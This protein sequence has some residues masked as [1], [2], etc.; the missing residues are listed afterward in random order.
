MALL[1]LLSRQEPR[2]LRR[3]RHG[4]RPTIPD[5]AASASAMLRDWGAE[6]K[7]HHVLKGYNYPHGGHPGRRPAREAAPPRGVDR[8]PPPAAARYYDQAFA[9]SGVATPPAVA[10][11]AA[12]SIT[13]TPSARPERARWQQE[14]TAQGRPDRHPLPDPGP[15]AAGL[16]GR[17][18]TSAG[19][20]P[21]SEK[22]ADEV[23]SL[24]MYPELTGVQ[25]DEVVAAVLETAKPVGSKPLNF[26]RPMLT[27]HNGS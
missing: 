14:L 20:F 3:R 26:S 13:S 27:R 15:P 22:A 19:D 23:L 8:S 2:R 24:P 25:Q 1:Q 7:Y 18:A 11:A 5:Y 10:T 9:G 21:H 17:R 12:T 6:Q 4:R 16:R